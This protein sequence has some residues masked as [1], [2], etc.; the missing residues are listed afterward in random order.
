[1]QR[2]KKVV[3]IAI[4][5]LILMGLFFIIYY[6]H[7]PQISITIYNHTN[8]DI[9]NLK[10]AYHHNE[11]DLEIP[12][13]QKESKYR[14]GITPNEKFIENSMWIYYFDKE[15]NKHEKTVIGYFE[16]GYHVNANVIIESINNDE[17]ITFKS[18]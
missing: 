9:S 13:I 10:I 11:K 5:S 6:F 17:I 2:S 7:Q 4:L 16:K 15:G 12:T 8:C 18:Q 14:V 1:M 3:G